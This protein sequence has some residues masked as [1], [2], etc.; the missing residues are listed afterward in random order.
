MAQKETARDW[1]VLGL[2]PGRITIKWLL[3]EWV[4]K[5]VNHL[6]I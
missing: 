5:Q 6:D 1:E 2:T 3:F 4:C